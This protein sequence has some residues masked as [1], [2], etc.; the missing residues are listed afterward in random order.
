MQVQNSPLPLPTVHVMSEKT[1][2]SCFG[3][4]VLNQTWVNVKC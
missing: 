4:I 2:R 1:G 3:G